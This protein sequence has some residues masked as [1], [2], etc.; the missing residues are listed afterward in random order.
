[1]RHQ[2]RGFA[3]VV[4]LALGVAIFATARADKQMTPS[5]RP[6]PAGWPQDRLTISNLGHACLLMN[7]FGVRILTD[8]SLFDRV[9]LAV[10]SIFTIGPRRVSAPPL[11]PVDLQDVQLILITHAHMDH[12]DVQSLKA[13]PKT[14][15]VVACDKCSRIIAPLGFADVRE[16]KWGE[17][18]EF[19]GLKITA[20]G[21][22][23]W[24]RRW[25][26]FGAD[27]G[28]DSFVLEKDAHRMLIACDSAYTDLFG[29]LARN[30][31]EVAVF[32]N[33]AYDPWIWNHANP[34]QVWSMFKQTGATYLLPIHW[35]T[36]KLGKEPMEEPMTRLLA[37]AGPESDRV[38]LR[39][40]G[41]TW[42]LP[43]AGEQALSATGR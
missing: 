19:S 25:P 1:M 10:D 8:P 13:L 22:R 32:S 28:F 11:A 43:Q 16:L 9:G 37:A 7:F 5:L 4:A 14:A 41:G 34:E 18:T 31:P 36:F 15:T 23:H 27:Y 24:G 6:N 38:V 2:L 20:M 29:E 21:A 26:P 39:E 35:G 33:G 17:S 42:T 3:V 40:I 30:P 12:L